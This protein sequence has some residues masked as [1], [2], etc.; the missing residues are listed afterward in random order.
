MWAGEQLLDRY[1]SPDYQQEYNIWKTKHTPIDKDE[2]MFP[3]LPPSLSLS[4]T[5]LSLSSSVELALDARWLPDPTKVRIRVY[6][7]Q[8][9]HKTLTALRQVFY[10]SLS[11]SYLLSLTTYTQQ[12]TRNTQHT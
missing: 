9:T 6:A 3:M 11:L 10:L 7:T 2:G 8:S 5:T 12:T 1:S 4:H